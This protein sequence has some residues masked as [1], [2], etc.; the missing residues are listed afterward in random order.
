MER[1]SVETI[2]QALEHA[3]VRYLIAGGLAVVAHGFVRFTAD[4][5]LVLDPDPGALRAAVTALDGLGYRPR[6]PVA[7]EEFADR[8]MRARWASEKGMSVFSAASPAHPATEIDLFLE[9]PF[10]FEAAHARA[11]RFELSPGVS[12]TFVSLADL[13]AMKRAVGR[14]QDLQDVAALEALR[15]ESGDPHDR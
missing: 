9:P 12:A 1:R 15:R 7:F 2:A 8:A 6:A 11:E 3:G 13:L 5:D 14:P 10:D 4:L